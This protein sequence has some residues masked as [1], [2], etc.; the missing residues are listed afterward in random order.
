MNSP[1]TKV[2]ARAL[3]PITVD[4]V[5][6]QNVTADVAIMGGVMM[7]RS[8]QGN[9]SSGGQVRAKGQI[10][11][12]TKTKPTLVAL[13]VNG[14]GLIPLRSWQHIAPNPYRST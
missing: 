8:S 4:R 12:P 7:V 3:T 5:E 14:M 10:A 13:D 2:S 9:L 11:F 6:L 1:I